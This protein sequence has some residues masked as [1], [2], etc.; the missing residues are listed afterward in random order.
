MAN[1]RPVHDRNSIAMLAV[2]VR[3][4]GELTDIASKKVFESA[5]NAA[6]QFGLN[7]EEEIHSVGFDANAGKLIKPNIGGYVFSSEEGIVSIPGLKIDFVN[8]LQVDKSSLMFRTTHFESWKTVADCI[9]P[10]F[11]PIIGIT[12]N[13][14]NVAQIRLEY[15][16]KFF[17]NGDENEA[18]T[19]ELIK[20]DSHYV[21]PHIFEN[22]KKWHCHVGFA[23]AREKYSGES[24]TQINMDASLL[25]SRSEPQ[26]ILRSIQ[27]MTAIETRKPYAEEK[28]GEYS[29]RDVINHLNNMHDDL[30]DLLREVVTE[31]MSR[32]I[33]LT[34]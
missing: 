16:D 30:N 1:W 5:E 12:S 13:I 7:R 27:I 4:T 32:K 22:R 14:I 34:K 26:E 10:L 19:D 11:S 20:R 15:L 33:G 2:V 25:K 29:Y 23:S 24:V 17:Y 6:R 31:D 18:K 21:S 28:E 9:E 3:F 8:Q